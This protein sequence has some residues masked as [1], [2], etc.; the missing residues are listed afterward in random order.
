LN[1]RGNGVELTAVETQDCETI[2]KILGGFETER[3]YF[4]CPSKEPPP[5]FP[6]CLSTA[7]CCKNAYCF[8]VRAAG[9]TVG[10]CAYR[11]IDY[12]NGSVTVWAAAGAG[13][14]GKKYRTE[15]IK[16]LS[17]NAF[18]QMRMEHIAFYC[19]EGD[20]EAAEAV[21]RA[22]FRRDAVLYSRIRSGGGSKNLELYT[23]LKNEA[24]F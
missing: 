20:S 3:Y 19:I 17:K 6:C 4:A 8:A 15:A 5:E 9:K 23:L 10:L 14:R 12:R 2:R 11:D 24:V 7:A 22:G 1:I 21:T 16:A 18:D 13:E